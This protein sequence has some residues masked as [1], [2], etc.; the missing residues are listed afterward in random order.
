MM[1][2]TITRTMATSTIHAFMLEIV[3]G[4]PKTTKLE[5]LIVMGKA[6]EKES[7]K[8]LKEKYGKNAVIKG[9]NLKEGATTIERNKQIGGHKA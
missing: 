7:I 9:M 6:T 3:D 1:R 5:P 2:K 4:Q 8:A